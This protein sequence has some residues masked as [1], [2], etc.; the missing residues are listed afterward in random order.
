FIEFGVEDFTEANTRFLMMNNNWSGYVMDGSSE[1][2]DRIR[3]AYYYWR[4]ELLAGHEFITAE[5]ISALLAKR[6]FER[7]GFLH[8]HIDGNDYWVWKAIESILPDIV[9]TEYNGVFGVDR[10]ITIPYQADFLRSKAHFSHLY[11][12]ASLAAMVRLGE[13]KGYAF[14][15]SNSAG[16]NAYF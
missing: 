10:A 11:A 8:I 9:V 3:S 1:C 7:V 6:P 5:N 13:E 15:G 4:H 2:V 14:I 16:N 12:G